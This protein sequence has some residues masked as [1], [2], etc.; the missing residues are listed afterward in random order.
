VILAQNVVENLGPIFSG[1]DLV[2]HADNVVSHPRNSMP[3]VA[4]AE[5]FRLPAYRA[6]IPRDPSRFVWFW[7]EH[8]DTP[9]RFPRLPC[10][11]NR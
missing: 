11:G 4:M 9:I 10:G 1:K 2:T 5:T 8:R 6:F 3:F 7:Q